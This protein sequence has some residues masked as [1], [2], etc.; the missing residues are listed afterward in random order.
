MSDV[1]AVTREDLDGLKLKR[2]SV[3]A[4][5]IG[6]GKVIWVQQPDGILSEELELQDWP[7]GDAGL[8]GVLHLNHKGRNDRWIIA[9]AVSS[10]GKPLYTNEDAESVRRLPNSLR[11]RIASRARDLDSAEPYEKAIE[12]EAK[13]SSGGQHSSSPTA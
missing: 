8:D 3:P 12:D 6:P 1:T 7:R 2:E 9:C 10:D 5:E 13:N 4:P 11:L